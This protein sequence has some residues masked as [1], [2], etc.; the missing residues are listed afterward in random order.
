MIETV[1]SGTILN[2]RYQI[3]RVLGSGGFGH[4][5]LALDQNLNQPF[6]VKEYLVS[7]PGGQEQLMHEANVLSQLHHPNLPAFHD[8]FH[9]HGRYY[10]VLNYIEGYDLTDIIRNTQKQNNV[11]PISQIMTWILATCDAV[12]FLHS[13]QPPVI[14]RDIKPDNIRI[15]P[16]GVAILVDLG[17]AKAAVDGARTLFF[18]RHQGTPG[19]APPEQYPGGSGTDTRSDIYA[20]GG[21]LYFAL[22]GQEPPSVSNR[23]QSMQQGQIDLPSLQEVLAKNPREDEVNPAKQFRLGVSK[24]A[25]PAPR[26]SRHLAQLATL[27][28]L[29][30]SQLNLVIQKAMAMRP[31]ERYQSIA[32][33]A[34]DLQKVVALMPGSPSVSYNTQPVNPAQ[35]PYK[36]QPDLPMV[37]DMI[38]QAKAVQAQA[39]DSE[40]SAEQIASNVQQAQSIAATPIPY[41]PPLKQEVCPRCGAPH[42]V[43]ASF[44]PHCGASLHGEQG[45]SNSGSHVAS[46][47]QVAQQPFTITPA[48]VSQ[49]QQSVMQQDT[50]SSPQSP[51]VASAVVQTQPDAIDSVPSWNTGS[52]SP[53]ISTS[54]GST[55]TTQSGQPAPR[56]SS[57]PNIG[58]LLVIL[59]VV[60]LLILVIILVVLLVQHA[61]QAMLPLQLQ[62]SLMNR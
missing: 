5:Y 9:E 28:P 56:M 33:F 7:G 53:S 18:I 61:H 22:T 47:H 17:N 27:S 11:V 1:P 57:S 36:T 2:G 49:N 35:N 15:M 55:S 50:L 4:V 3:E 54:T 38:Q 51:V 8:A 48:P 60:I 13:Q 58:L 41:T 59:L 31:R 40:S 10:V 23:N 39:H 32:D 44:C 6:A 45:P 21:T 30:L 29:A 42:K 20:L 19:Y 37:Y 26:H 16:N 43:G 62:L 46:T 12:F 34:N 24:P 52:A 25:K 14:H